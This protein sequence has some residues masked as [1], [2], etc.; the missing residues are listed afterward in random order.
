[1]MTI[2]ERI[3]FIR[4]EYTNMKNEVLTKVNIEWLYM[5]KEYLVKNNKMLSFAHVLFRSV[6]TINQYVYGLYNKP[7]K[8]KSHFFNISQVDWDKLFV[9]CEKANNLGFDIISGYEEKKNFEYLNETEKVELLEVNEAVINEY[10]ELLLRC[11]VNYLYEEKA[12]IEMMNLFGDNHDMNEAELT[13]FA[14]AA[15]K[16]NVNVAYVKTQE[17]LEK[18]YKEIYLEA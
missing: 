13:A 12:F 16:R 5:N 8:Y 2:E 11:N 6:L 1:M 9:L 3:E 18:I 4:E 17:E 7:N 10:F 14:N 15:L